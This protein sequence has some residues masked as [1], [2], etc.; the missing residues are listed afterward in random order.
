MIRG[1]AQPIAEAA[2]LV[3]PESLQSLRVD[4]AGRI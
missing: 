4:V 2:N 1:F 3:T